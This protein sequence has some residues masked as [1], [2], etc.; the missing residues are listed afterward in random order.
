MVF[1]EC[2]NCLSDEMVILCIK[3]TFIA[4]KKIVIT[5]MH[6]IESLFGIQISGTS[7][8]LA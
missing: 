4:G 7:V 3:G 5:V 1:K 8:Y 2:Q 6:A